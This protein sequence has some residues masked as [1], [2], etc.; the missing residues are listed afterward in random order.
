[1]DGSYIPL[2]NYPALSEIPSPVPGD[3]IEITT[4]TTTALNAASFNSNYAVVV[5]NNGKIFTSTDNIAWTQQ[6][7]GTTNTLYA[8]TNSQYG[9]FIAGSSGLILK[10]SDAIN[11]SVITKVS[12]H[13]LNSAFSYS[14]TVILVGN[15][16]EIAVSTNGSS[17]ISYK[18]NNSVY[19]DVVYNGTN[20]IAV[21]NATITSPNGTTWTNRNSLSLN[22][23]CNNAGFLV[24]V[25]DN[26][27]IVTSSDNGLNW[28]TRT[29]NIS[30]NLYGISILNGYY[31]ASGD[32]GIILK[33]SDA[34][35][36]ST[37]N[38][39]GTDWQR[40]SSYGI[41][42]NDIVLTGQDGSVG[43]LHAPLTGYKFLPLLPSPIPWLFTYQMRAM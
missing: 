36:W 3:D 5:G 40:H 16:G 15:N 34:I 29:S 8:I 12:N 35:N 10:S 19:R 43:V 39:T 42:G 11:W 28:T 17:F 18:H 13:Q 25:G 9:F 30:D 20:W 38:N 1:M 21:G 27:L 6:T 14:G 33:S 7:S 32:N 31:I 41:N 23:I 4:V 22:G 24:A 26:G 2:T 37:I